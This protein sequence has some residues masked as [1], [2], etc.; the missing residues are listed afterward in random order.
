[1]CSI[2][3]TETLRR[4][5]TYLQQ[6]AVNHELQRE[7]LSGAG[8]T[9]LF[10]K[11][12]ATFYGKKFVLTF[13][14]ATTAMNA[15]CLAYQFKGKEILTSPFNWGGSVAPYLLHGNRLRFTA[16]EPGTLC[17]SANDLDQAVSSKTKA[18]I[19]VD[20]HGYPVDSLRIKEFCGERGLVYISDSAQSLGARRDDRPAGYYADATVFSFSAGKTVYAGEGGAVVTDDEALYEKLLRIAHHPSRQKMVSGLSGYT[21]FCA[22]NGRINP[23]ASIVLNTT[24]EASLMELQEKQI[25]LFRIVERLQDEKLI[26]LPIEISSPQSS[27]W[28]QPV[29]LMRESV[30]MMDVLDCCQDIDSAITASEPTSLMPISSNHSFCREFKKQYVCS[31]TLKQDLLIFDRRRYVKLGGRSVGL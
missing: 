15:L 21:E 18:V 8:E 19:S 27:A 24:F 9:Y 16:F 20:Y 6:C 31:D 11:K 2:A 28:F 12:L 23:L 13:S 4:L 3:Y 26:H 17:L 7:H 22:L 1:M 29:F 10:E 30:G 25:R 14:S 5:G